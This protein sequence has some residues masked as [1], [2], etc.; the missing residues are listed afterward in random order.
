MEIN[1]VCLANVDYFQ[2]EP[3]EMHNYIVVFIKLQYVFALEDLLYY[4]KLLS[5]M[6]NKCS[7]I[8]KILMSTSYMSLL[9]K[10][11]NVNLN[12]CPHNYYVPNTEVLK[13]IFILQKL[14]KKTY[15]QYSNESCYVDYQRK[16]Y[17]LNSLC[18]PQKCLK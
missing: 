2:N 14:V 15:S 16:S 5:R 9:T 12:F 13:D 7:H 1:L 17:L 4:Y 6:L 18:K 11:C 8:K 3:H 10:S